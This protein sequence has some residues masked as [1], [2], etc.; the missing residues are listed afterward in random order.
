M[1]VVSGS[2]SPGDLYWFRATE[3]GFEEGRKIPETTDGVE[4]AASAAFFAD[5]DGD[6][7]LDMLVGNISGEVHWIANEGTKREFKFGARRPVEAAGA[8][9]KVS[10]DA[11]PV[12]ADWDRDG[13]PDLVV[14]SGDGSIV[15]CKGTATKSGPPTLARPSALV[16]G[17]KPIALGKRVKIAVADWNGDGLSDLLAGNFNYRK[18]GDKYEYTGNVYVMVR[19][20]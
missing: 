20:K 8:P 13:T 4:R 14:G 11:H 16:A 19:R 3:K 1:D 2:Y 18:N 10:D 7:D 5:W 6:G 9:L 15:W 12:V 17:G